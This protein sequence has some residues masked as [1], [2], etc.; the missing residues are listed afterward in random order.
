MAS[1]RRQRRA[2]VAMASAGLRR[3]RVRDIGVVFEK[4]TRME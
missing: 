3:L 1:G 2:V 4:P